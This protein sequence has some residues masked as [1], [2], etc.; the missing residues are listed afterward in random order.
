V[1][2]DRWELSRIMPAARCMINPYP[3]IAARM[4]APA[5]SMDAQAS[6]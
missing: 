4:G 2:V 3:G 5:G 6:E 1:L